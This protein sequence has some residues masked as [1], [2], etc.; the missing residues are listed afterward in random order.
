MTT[1]ELGLGFHIGSLGPTYAD[2]IQVVVVARTNPKSTP[3]A[4][5]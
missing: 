1:K 5:V 2:G 4:S 3:I